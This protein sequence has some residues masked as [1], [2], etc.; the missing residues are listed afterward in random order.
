MI[1]FF[2]LYNINLFQKE[3]KRYKGT[4]E[5]VIQYVKDTH[6]VDVEILS[7]NG[8]KNMN[9]TGGA[10][11][12]TKDE[13]ELKFKIEIS[14]FNN[15][16]SDTY[17]EESSVYSLNEALQSSEEPRALANIGADSVEI[18][19]PD[20]STPW[21]GDYNP[22]FYFDL[23]GDIR[24][25]SEE[26][27]KVVN[28]V[29]PVAEEWKETAKNE[30]KLNMEEIHFESFDDE[31]K[32]QNIRLNI[33]SASNDSLEELEA[34]IL[35]ENIDAFTQHL[36]KEEIR[37]IDYLEEQFDTLEFSDSY[38]REYLTCNQIQQLN[39]CE[40]Y[41]LYVSYSSRSPVEIRKEFRYDDPNVKEMLLDTIQ[42]INDSESPINQL[43]ID[44]LYRPSDLEHQYETEEELEENNERIIFDSRETIINN[45]PEIENVEDIIFEE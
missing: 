9:N 20:T 29:L 35:E 12:Q 37:R 24:L 33:E 30:Y 5:E 39:E 32:L 2:L 22:F 18:Q 11:V 15:I 13:R 43:S 3:N 25:S 17:E 41:T 27:I 31:D 8:P 6:D 38:H 26:T 1:A 4:D 42:K 44:M 21:H 19:L 16:K 7:N 23:S 28:E 45:L 34:R 36:I 10:T 14:I 40:S